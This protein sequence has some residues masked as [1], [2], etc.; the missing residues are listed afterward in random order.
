M[1][2]PLVAI[3][4]PTYNG[5][6]FLDEAMQSVQAQTY[7]N[8]VHVVLD[9][10]STD[11]T[12]EIIARYKDARVPVMAFRNASLLPQRE[13]WNTAFSHVPDAA[14]YVRL[15]CDDDTIYPDGIEKMVALAEQ[16]PEIGIVG[17]LHWCDGGITD[18]H[19]PEAQS[20]YDGREA[21]RRHLLGEGRLMPIHLLMRKSVVDRR[22][23]L[24]DDFLVGGFDVDTTIALL[25]E[26]KFGF[27]HECLAFTRVHENTVSNLTTK[28]NNARTRDAFDLLRRYGP[29]VFG[30]RHRDLEARFRRYY[31][32]R[33]LRWR[34]AGMAAEHLAI[35]FEALKQAQAPFG[36]RLLGE[37]AIDW[38]LIRLG[39]RQRWTG[40]PGWQ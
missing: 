29:E 24:F 23:P 12:D 26:T 3:V 8:L 34:R 21:I 10:A 11:G 36:P 5:A 25:L 28:A 17:C 1:D 31:A 7:P 38:I 18:F 20:V 27:V 32:R 15:L 37:A 30:D 4:T 19:W 6:A 40:Y 16:D 13:N 9:N 14:T 39:L 2:Y 35:H 33:I 22:T